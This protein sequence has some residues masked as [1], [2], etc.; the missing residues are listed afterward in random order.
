M[1][2]VAADRNFQHCTENGND[3]EASDKNRGFG[4]GNTQSWHCLTDAVHTCQ[5][6]HPSV[7]VVQLRIVDMRD[8]QAME[9]DEARFRLLRIE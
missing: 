2:K 8:I 7:C 3:G 5:L 1:A 4:I 9:M 6:A